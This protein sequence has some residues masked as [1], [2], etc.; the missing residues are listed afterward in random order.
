MTR[1][2]VLEAT[3]EAMGAADQLADHLDRMRTRLASWFPLDGEGIAAWGD[4]ERE[5]LHAL[6]RMFHRLYDLTSRKLVRGLLFLSG[7][8]IAGLSA[9]NQ[10]RRAEAIGGLP[11]ADRWIELGATLNILAH[12]YPTRSEAQAARANLAW[13]ILPALVDGTRRIVAQLL[14]ERLI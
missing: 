13:R 12:D 1:D 8:T 10:F 11:D 3:R 6:L 2:E 9:Q 5:R 7:E 4:D 14:S